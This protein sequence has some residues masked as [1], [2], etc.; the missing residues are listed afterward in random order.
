MGWR[1]DLRNTYIAS[2]S[3]FKTANPTLLDHIYEAR[4][5]DLP[6][7]A[8]IY[9]GG[10]SEN[11]RHDSG[12][13]QRRAEVTLVCARHLG[14]NEETIDDLEDLAD[15]LVDWLTTNYG[16]T[17]THTVQEPVRTLTAEI[18]DGATPTPAIAVV[19]S[20]LIQQGR[21]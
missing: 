20:A 13:R 4:P 7:R 17:G 3:L 5:N 6:D 16:L 8:S 15:A 10:I 11:I 9:I 19:T 21:L 14:D 12:T 18:L 2:L 1:G